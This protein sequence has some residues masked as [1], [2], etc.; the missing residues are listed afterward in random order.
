[1]SKKNDIAETELFEIYFSKDRR[2]R[3]DRKFKPHEKEKILEAVSYTEETLSKI[4]SFSKF[5]LNGII[6]RVPVIFEKVSKEVFQK[7]HQNHFAMIDYPPIGTIWNKTLKFE[8]IEIKATTA[9]VSICPLQKE[10]L[11]ETIS[12]ETI[13]AFHNSFLEP[14][15]ANYSNKVYFLESLTEWTT[16]LTSSYFNVGKKKKSKSN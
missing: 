11:F 15:G 10:N 3:G 8:G 4:L 12:H 6:Y 9:V 5:P 7:K 13:H 14:N 16:K 2:G 1:M